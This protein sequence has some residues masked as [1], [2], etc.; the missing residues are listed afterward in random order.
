MPHLVPEHK[1]PV[2]HYFLKFIN[3]KFQTLDYTFGYVILNPF[4]LAKGVNLW[5]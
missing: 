2:R 4:T 1:D 5:G 3:Y